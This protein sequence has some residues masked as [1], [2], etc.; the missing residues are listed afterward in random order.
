MATNR[1]ALSKD[2]SVV[3]RARRLAEARKPAFLK[4]AA[5]LAMSAPKMV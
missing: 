2:E 5:S 1:L 3:E 4:N